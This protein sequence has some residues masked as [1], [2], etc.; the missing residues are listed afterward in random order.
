MP[1]L[2]KAIDSGKR[3][4]EEFTHVDFSGEFI[5][6]L[7]KNINTEHKSVQIQSENVIELALHIQQELFNKKQIKE[8]THA[9]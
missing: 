9:N 6:K 1:I 7:I 4:P 8:K 2:K 5:Q 3:D